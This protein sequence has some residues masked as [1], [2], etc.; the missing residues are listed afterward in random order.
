MSQTDGAYVSAMA[1]GVRTSVSPESVI[2]AVRQAVTEVGPSATLYRTTTGPAI[3]SRSLGRVRFNGLVL[4]IFAG[5]GLLLAATGVYGVTAY[6]VGRRTREC[7]L[8]M[9]L[10]A[11]RPQ[12]IQ[13]LLRGAFLLAMTG[14]GAGLVASL[15]L[16]RLLSDVFLAVEPFDPLVYSAV[17]A[18]LAAVVLV[19][20]Y[21]PARRATRVSPTVA[22]RDD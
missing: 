2:P 3:V 21:L 19:A 14:V 10:G 12:I 22:L 13:T 9:A 16:T 1:V 18:L 5:V 8:R 7:G 4:L 6:A 15:A 20:T 11:P 17:S